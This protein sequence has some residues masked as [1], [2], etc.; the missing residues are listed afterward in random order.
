M[1][2]PAALPRSP[3]AALEQVAALRRAIVAALEPVIVG[4]R[5][6]IDGALAAVVSGGHCLLEGVPGLA[7]T[8]LV[9]SLAAALGLDFGRIQF[10][11]DLMPAD[12][13]G[14][15]VL[16]EE[17]DPATALS[18]VGGSRRLRFLP[19][20]VFRHV[21]LADEI[22]RAPPKTQSALLEAMQEGH[23]T[24]GG[25][26]HPLPQP[27]LVLA[28]RNPIE[29]EGTYPLPEGQL[30]R[31]MFMLRVEYP[32]ALEELEI[33]RRSG[34]ERPVVGPVVD[35]AAVDAARR[36]VRSLPVADHVLRRAVQLV[37]S[38][39]PTAAESP[40]WLRDLVRFGAG[41]RATQFLVLAAKAIAALD[42]RPCVELGDV[43]RAAPAVLR[44]RLVTTFE[45]ES[46]GIR[47]DAIVQRLL[48]GD[49]P[50]G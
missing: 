29:Q 10:T 38:T 35:R 31:F 15:E 18:P 32:D 30:D 39:R 13:T 17:R 45:A 42:G 5:E 1:N 9:K 16:E 22:N 20:P 34:D 48:G 43:H 11:P 46:E 27:F 44:H 8:L 49:G 28:T 2:D 23:V 19:G 33:V 24:V 21:L 25:T 14:T 37:R 47:P 7:K 40:A 6:V 12:I 41:P 26:T 4:Q 50:G 3:A 36:I